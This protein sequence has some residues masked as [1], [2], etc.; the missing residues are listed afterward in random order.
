M[1]LVMLHCRALVLAHDTSPLVNNG[2]YICQSITR[3]QK[4]CMGGQRSKAN[5]ERGVTRRSREAEIR[6]R[7]PKFISVDCITERQFESLRACDCDCMS[8]GVQPL[9]MGRK[10]LY[11]LPYTALAR[12]GVDSYE[13]LLQ[14]EPTLPALN[15]DF[16]KCSKRGVLRH[17]DLS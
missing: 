14:F 2:L 16:G 8:H 1:L 10:T 4:S 15:G 11:V 13:H 3:M 6:A 17:L 5:H 12:I 9:E 7:L